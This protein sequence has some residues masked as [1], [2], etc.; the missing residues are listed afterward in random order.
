[1]IAKL[2][3]PCAACGKPIRSAPRPGARHRIY[4]SRAR[5][6]RARAAAVCRV[7]RAANLDRERA[8]VRAWA[9]ANRDKANRWGR[10]NPDAKRA[11]QRRTYHARRAALGLAATP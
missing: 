2:G 10:A 5:C 7:Y 11:G 1:M 3:A 8:R 6:L 9:A 4:C